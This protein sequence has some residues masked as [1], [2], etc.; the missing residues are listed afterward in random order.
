MPSD[1]TR[2]ETLFGWVITVTD[3][4]VGLLVCFMF[5]DALSS[6]DHTVS[7]GGMISE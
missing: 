2:T 3:I 5:N 6:S 4:H 1:S 7:N